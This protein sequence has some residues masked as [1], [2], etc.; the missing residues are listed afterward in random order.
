MSASKKWFECN[1]CE[2]RLSS[3]KSL[4]R[5]KKICKSK[6]DDSSTFN[7]RSATRSLEQKHLKDND[8]DAEFNTYIDQIINGSPKKHLQDEQVVGEG[9][10]ALVYQQKEENPRK[11]KDDKIQKI[12]HAN[13]M[14]I[15]LPCS[16]E[17]T[18]VGT[19]EVCSNLNKKNDQPDT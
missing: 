9:P 12:D 11:L 14:D 16:S 13:D 3:Y 18:E 7:I 1:Q 8:K 19:S 17:Q 15:S 6:V 4:W 10:I 5:H 2:K